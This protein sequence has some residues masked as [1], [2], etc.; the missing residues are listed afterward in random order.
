MNTLILW[1]NYIWKY[2][3]SQYPGTEMSLF[4]EEVIWKVN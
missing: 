3:I 1:E 2:E 4:F